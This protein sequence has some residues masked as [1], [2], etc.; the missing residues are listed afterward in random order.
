MSGYSFPILSDQELLPCLKEM[1]LPCSAAQ[2]AKP[3]YEVVRP[4]YE[5]MVTTLMGITREELQQ[6]VFQAIVALEFPELHDE[7]IP[8]VA[9]TKNLGKLMAAAGVK[10]FT[11][12]DLYKPDAQRL[13]RNL[14]AIINFAKFREEKLVPYTEMQEATEGILAERQDLE[15]LNRQLM[16][17][18]RRLQAERASEEPDVARLEA[19]IHEVYTENQQLNKQQA[20]LNSEVRA[21]KQQTNVLA[22]EAADLKF[23]LANARQEGDQLR[24]LIVESPEKLQAMLEEIQAA[25]E[26]ERSLVAEAERK[27]RDLQARLDTV[28]K[29]EKE[30]QKAQRVMEEVESE[31]AKKKAIS[32]QV[33]ELRSQISGEEQEALQLAA[34]Q[35]HLKRQQASLA[36]RMQ[37]LEQQAALKK[38][39]AASCVEEQLRDKEAIEAENAAT[40]AKLTE[41]DAMMRALREKIK[42][43]QTTQE[44]QISMVLDRYTSL[45]QQVA[46]YHTLLE[47][48]MTPA[49][50]SAAVKAVTLR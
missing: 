3:T 32:R 9:F 12:Q 45:R 46:E 29:V 5:S 25:V 16:S 20:T 47:A 22:D 41:N 33:K 28:A 36:E 6:P 34:T 30:V 23:K 35:Q 4:L 7:S 27:A 19:D 11:M 17:E 39:A 8:A 26:R 50:R 21:M 1:E 2:L 15:D 14:S 38:E 31:L 37:R 43:L 40:M 13:R 18:L 10:D 24:S 48:A 49:S 42:E 44:V